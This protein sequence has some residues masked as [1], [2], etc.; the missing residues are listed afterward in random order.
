MD[1]H[2][3]LGIWVKRFEGRT[4]ISWVKGTIKK[5]S[6]QAAIQ[7]LRIWLWCCHCNYWTLL[8]K[9]VGKH[10][11]F[12]YVILLLD[13][14]SEPLACELIAI[15]FQSKL[16]YVMDERGNSSRPTPAGPGPMGPY[17]PISQ[18]RCPRPISINIYIYIYVYICIYLSLYIYNMHI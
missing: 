6:S 17:G 3:N 7:N 18:P 13:P 14:F 9:N 2:P 11:W 5:K 4:G 8:N 10:K 12:M 15:L 16:I 1:K